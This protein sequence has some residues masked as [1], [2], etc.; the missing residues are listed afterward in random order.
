MLREAP[1]VLEP[2]IEQLM[3]LPADER[4]ATAFREGQVVR[5]WPAVLGA[6]GVATGTAVGIVESVPSF[7]PHHP[8]RRRAMYGVRIHYGDGRPPELVSLYEPELLHA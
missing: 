8:W 6:R 1:L 7:R 5:L 2:Y 4:P 3:A